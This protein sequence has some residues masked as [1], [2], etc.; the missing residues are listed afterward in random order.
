M[1][2]LR[3]LFPI[4][5]IIGLGAVSG[6]SGPND[7]P[8][9]LTISQCIEIS[10]SQNPLWL[11]SEHDV[12]ASLARIERA[13]AR[14]RPNLDFDSDLQPGFLDFGGSGESYL[15]VSQILE[16]PGRRGLRT[17]IARLES[18]EAA[19]RDLGIHKTTLF[20]RIKR[21]GLSFPGPDGRSRRRPP[22]RS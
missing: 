13:K 12:R 15:G 16:F 5:L 1:A 20:R 14:P 10:L 2:R 3:G 18:E 19:A 21:L 4:I 8:D 11:S 22:D 7:L 6:F 9:G 17:R